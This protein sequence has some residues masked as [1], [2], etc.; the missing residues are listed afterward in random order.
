M[1][2]RYVAFYD[3][4]PNSGVTK[5]L[6]SQVDSLRK[7]NVDSKLILLDEG[8]KTVSFEKHYVEFVP[9]IFGKPKTLRRG[10]RRIKNT[11]RVFKEIFNC[12]DANDFVIIRGYRPYPDIFFSIITNH[13][14][15]II[16]DLQSIT[17]TEKE[18]ASEKRFQI[19]NSVFGRLLIK[20]ADGLIAVT[21]EIADYYSHKVKKAIPKKVV[22]NGINVSSTPLRSFPVF[23]GTNIDLLCVAQVAKWH[24]L[25]RL[26][27]GIAQY[28]GKKNIKL[29]I[30]GNGVE[31]PNLKKLTANLGLN[32]QIIFHGFKTGKEL[33]D[34]FD[35][36][37]I[38]VG[39]LAIHRKGLVKTSE[40]KIR[41]Y[42]ARGI[43]FINSAIDPDFPE[44]FPYR[45]KVPADE[46]P[47]NIQF[48]IKFVEKVYFDT[49]HASKM[50]SF[51]E[52]NLDWSVK[53]KGLI[54]F[55]EDILVNEEQG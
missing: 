50:R 17:E 33:D 7:L 19:M 37:H 1:K 13:K 48:V 5:K 18:L 32:D 21:S 10:I 44:S 2:V 51:A 31:L 27:N 22:E 34:F 28:K 41:E 23:D 12:L 6:L 53:M 55:M 36:C 49:N 4:N 54:S 29:H 16:F 15:K 30:V 9:M 39:S 25:D 24:G 14:C 26:I 43:P 47:V 45:L 11:R 8:T 20:K 35:R 38:A 46:S 40:L 3:G 42:C 52:K